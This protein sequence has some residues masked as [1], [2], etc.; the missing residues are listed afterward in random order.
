MIELKTFLKDLLSLPGLSG[1]EGPVRE[2]IAQEW[3]PLVDELYV[4]KVGSLHGLRR[5]HGP[6]QRPRILLAAHMDA[7]GMMVTGV[8][9]GFLRLTEV[10]GLDPRILPGQP[11]TVHGRRDV[12][13]LIVQPPDRLLSPERN[14]S[15]AKLG[16]LLVDTG[17]L[18]DEV[19]RLV[20][21]GDLVSYAQ[22]P[23]ELS[24]DV[25]SGHT[26]DNRASVTAITACL[27]ELQH[28]EH[29]WDVWAVATT[30]EEETFAGAYT[31]PWEIRPDI[32]IALDVTFAK[33]PNSTDYRTYDMNKGPTLGWGPNVHPAIHQAIKAVAEKLDIPFQIEPMPRHSG[34][35]AFALQVVAEGIPTMVIGIP[36]RYMHTPVESVS[37]K[38]IERAG[39]L[40]AE[41]IARLEPD[42]TKNI[43]WD[44]PDE[45]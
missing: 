34:T 11:V 2:R 15:P 3:R 41:F 8:V 35:D 17:L 25:I 20:R 31:S 42:F 43:R 27:Q 14:G 5:G 26:Q 19:G 1:N 22:P 29:A 18:P 38:D 10:G 7:V 16:D 39:H 45:H 24:G 36:L 6:E 12:P 32:A 30:Q 44:E 23:L 40:L 4:S 9:D 28:M 33:G 21:T 13:G 37:F